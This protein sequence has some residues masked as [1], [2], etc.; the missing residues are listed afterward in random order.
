[1]DIFVAGEQ[2]LRFAGVREGAPM[3]LLRSSAGKIKAR[4]QQCVHMATKRSVSLRA[5]VLNAHCV[6]AG[7]GT[8]GTITG[9][10]QYLKEK[11]PSVQVGRPACAACLARRS[12]AGP[13]RACVLQTPCRCPSRPSNHQ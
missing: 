1:M 10:A 4:A 6:R 11:K 9:T 5:G 12:D 7:V 13:L 2:W 8:G 3:R